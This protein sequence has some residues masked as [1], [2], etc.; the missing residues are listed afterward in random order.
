M[1]VELELVLVSAM[2]GRVPSFLACESPHHPYHQLALSLCFGLSRTATVMKVLGFASGASSIHT[3]SEV[4]NDVDA[5][6]AQVCRAAINLVNDS[7]FLALTRRLNL[8][9]TL[10]QWHAYGSP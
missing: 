5:E 10:V 6:V 3:E 2:V 1:K 7:Y 8:S 9:C 4:G